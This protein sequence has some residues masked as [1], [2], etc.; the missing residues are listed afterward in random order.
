MLASER[1]LE[2]QDKYG[3]KVHKI[4]P[5]EPYSPFPDL[6]TMKTNQHINTGVCIEYSSSLFTQSGMA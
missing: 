4:V 3:R 2:I 1:L 5:L 6:D